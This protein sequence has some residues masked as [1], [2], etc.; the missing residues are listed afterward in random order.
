MERQRDRSDW[1]K[2]Q[3]MVDKKKRNWQGEKN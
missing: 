3:K 2:R 1:E